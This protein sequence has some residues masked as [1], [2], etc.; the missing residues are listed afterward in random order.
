MNN[1]KLY[2]GS[3]RE[4]SVETII[5]SVQRF[6]VKFRALVSR[7]EVHYINYIDTSYT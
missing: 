1:R 6:S 3:S 7:L 5:S 2:L 4:S